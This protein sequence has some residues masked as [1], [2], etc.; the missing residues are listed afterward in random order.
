MSPHA[1]RFTRRLS[2]SVLVVDVDS[3]YTYLKRL[4]KPPC[5]GAIFPPQEQRDAF[6][7]VLGIIGMCAVLA[8]ASASLGAERHHT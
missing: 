3:M 8:D 7:F 6:G 1:R 2:N 4:S 5:G